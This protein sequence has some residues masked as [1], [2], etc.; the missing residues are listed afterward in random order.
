[1]FYPLKEDEKHKMDK[2]PTPK[3]ETFQEIIPSLWGDVNKKTRFFWKFVNINK[4]RYEN[5]LIFVE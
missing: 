5:V 4:K 1:M 2:N 3:G